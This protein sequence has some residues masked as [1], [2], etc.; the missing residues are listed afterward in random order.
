MCLQISTN[1][2]SLDRPE[3][4]NSE[5][6][7]GPNKIKIDRAIASFRFKRDESYHDPTDKAYRCDKCIISYDY[8]HT[9]LRHKK[10]EHLN[11][12][13]DF[14]EYFA[15]FSYIGYVKNNPKVVEPIV[16]KIEETI[17]NNTKLKII[18]MNVNSLVHKNRQY[19]V[20]KGITNSKAE[21]VISRVQS[22][23]ILSGCQFNKKSRCWWSTG[24]GKENCKDSFHCC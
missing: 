22:P 3:T 13:T 14:N 24:H 11:P 19:N 5:N 23:R 9:L 8:E 15:S 16:G 17:V 20:R 1:D 2:P 7:N 10:H 12:D 18:Y 4:E 6:P 21:V